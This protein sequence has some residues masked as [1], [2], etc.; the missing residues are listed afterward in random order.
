[1][2]IVKTLVEN[3][4]ISK[5]Y[6]CKHGLC[7]YIET[8]KHRILFDLGQDDLFIK[9]AKEMNIDLSLIDTVIISH[10]HKDH[11]GAL[12]YLLQVNKTAKIYIKKDAFNP[13]YIKVLGIPINVGLDNSL[14]NNE[15]IIL[16]DDSF[17]IDDE[18]YLFSNIEKKF[19]LSKSNEV[20]FV[21]KEGKLIKDDFSH[22]QSLLININNKSTLIS[23]CSHSGIVN[24]LNKALKITDNIK[25][26]IGGFHLYNPPTKKYEKNDLIDLIADE[27]SKYDCDFYTCHCTGKRAFLM[28]KDKLKNRLNY[29]KTG[30]IIEL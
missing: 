5:K 21:K 24:I 18:L 29:L 7:L 9:N 17:K 25:T 3:T 28:M 23:G 10:G 15:R 27:L 1:M 8:A 11:G 4:T 2:L 12:K 14:I 13:H 16:T 20:L 19:P 26:V 30:S 22:E 6:R